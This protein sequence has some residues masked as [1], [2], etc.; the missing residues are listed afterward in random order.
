MA[1]V[2]CQADPDCP[3]PVAADKSE[4]ICGPCLLDK[5]KT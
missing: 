3:E 1:A 2:L 5:A 4:V